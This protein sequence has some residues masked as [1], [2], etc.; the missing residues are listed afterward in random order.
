MKLY[1]ISKQHRLAAERMQEM[2]EEGVI[3]SQTLDDTL[4]GLGFDEKASGVA[5]YIRELM[6]Y[7][8][9]IDNE[10]KRLKILSEHAQNNVEG[11][12]K[13][14]LHN[15]QVVN[16]KSL[17]TSLI[18]LFIRDSKAVEILDEKLIDNSFKKTTE[19]IK[20]DKIAIKAALN[21]G[22]DVRGAK[23]V[24]NQSLQIK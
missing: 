24:T 6:N 5:L 2:L 10:I 8:E 12:K 19:I 11:W 15:M 1:E 17:K 16:K 23:L 9:A 14:L 20:I 18:T 4:D 21:N 3:D 22:V 13:Y 7:K